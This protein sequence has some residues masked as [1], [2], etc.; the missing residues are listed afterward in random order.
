MA[1]SAICIQHPRREGRLVASRGRAGGPGD[2][3]ARGPAPTVARHRCAQLQ[4]SASRPFSHVYYAN[5]KGEDAMF[6]CRF[7]NSLQCP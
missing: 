4:H 1:G 5:V 7:I 6:F 3:V 2:T